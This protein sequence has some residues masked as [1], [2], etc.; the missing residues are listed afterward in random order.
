MAVGVLNPTEGNF[1]TQSVYL[2]EGPI[3]TVGVCRIGEAV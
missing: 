3:M 2:N 1:H